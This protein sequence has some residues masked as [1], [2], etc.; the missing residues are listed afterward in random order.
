VN[1]PEIV[2]GADEPL[3]ALDGVILDELRA[4]WLAADPMPA[5]LLDRIHFA[6]ELQDVDVAVMRLTQVH[7]P[8]AAR[9]E[10]QSRLVT[11]D[12]ES[13]TIMVNISPAKDGSIRIDGWLT[14][15]ASHPIEL[16]TGNGKISTRSDEGGR[17]ALHPV[18]PGMAQLVVDA[19]GQTVT[20]PA[21]AL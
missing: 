19:A 20:T 18:P 4:A 17:F 16:R 12:S 9:G 1:V 11:F 13:L 15:P 14:P 21:I 8:A 10:E 6:V 7:Q 3:D 5:D 2:P